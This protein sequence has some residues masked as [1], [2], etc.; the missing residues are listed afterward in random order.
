MCCFVQIATAFG[1][2]PPPPFPILKC[3]KGV[4][5]LWKWLWD[6]RWGHCSHNHSVMYYESLSYSWLCLTFVTMLEILQSVPRLDT[7]LQGAFSFVHYVLVEICSFSVHLC[8][9]ISQP[10]WLTSE[11]F[12]PNPPHWPSELQSPFQNEELYPQQWMQDLPVLQC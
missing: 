5:K 9:P 4:I 11:L 7:Y 2:P 12:P 6:E 8:N 3:K 1:P 10:H